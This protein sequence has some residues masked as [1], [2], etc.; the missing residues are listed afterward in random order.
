M[1]ERTTRLTS[2]TVI[3][4][5]LWSATTMANNQENAQ[6][7]FT[8]EP[9]TATYSAKIKKGISLSGTAIRQLKKKG[10]N[11]WEY[12]FDVESLPVDIRETV[13]FEWQDSKVTPRNYHYLL[14]GILI[15]DKER[16]IEFDWK[17]NSASGQQ[18]KDKW[19]IDIP[20]F[21]QDRLSY[22]LQLLADIAVN[23]TPL[24]YQVVHKGRIEE[25]NFQVIRKEKI[26]TSIGEQNSIVVEKIRAPDRP[27][28]TLLWFS[29]S[30]PLL[31]LKMYQL[32]KNGEEYEIILQSVTYD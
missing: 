20:E 6:K 5:L 23:K 31:L 28:K 11:K 19:T 8:F 26:P 7:S 12:R 10:E 32:E 22:Q 15:R 1:Q 25:S 24:Q 29:E 30:Q 3:A 14:T 21:A 16:F 9:Y 27:R 4:L 2:L 18:R 17:K 13:V